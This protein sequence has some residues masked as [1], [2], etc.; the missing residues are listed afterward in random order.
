[1]C[2]A[3]F[4]QQP[5]PGFLGIP[6]QNQYFCNITEFTTPIPATFS[7]PTCLED[8]SDELD[9]NSRHKHREHSHNDRNNVEKNQQEFGNRK[10]I[11]P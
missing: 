7:R 5:P 4:N 1:M 8:F 11:K 2:F 9:K 3:Y 10:R 6:A